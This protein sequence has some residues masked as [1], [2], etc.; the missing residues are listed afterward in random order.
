ML[1]QPIHTLHRILIRAADPP[2]R[3][4]T[5]P[6]D[7]PL[8]LC[9]LQ[10]P[11]EARE[12]VL[13]IRRG[14]GDPLVARLL[15]PVLKEERAGDQ[16]EQGGERVERGG[17]VSLQSRGGGLW[18]DS[19]ADEVGDRRAADDGGGHLEKGPEAAFLDKSVAKLAD[20]NP[21]QN[22]V[23]DKDNDGGDA[24]SYPVGK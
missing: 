18:P 3:R 15:Q 13:V 11:L 6:R 23:H 24:T 14:L 19:I 4:P 8:V 1:R 5:A 21:V 17:H 12:A 10:I 9:L 16:R 22:D 7:D 20:I 2:T